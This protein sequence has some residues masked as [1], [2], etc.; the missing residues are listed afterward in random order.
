[1]RNVGLQ[2]STMR[3][4]LL[5]ITLTLGAFSAFAGN[6][7]GQRIGDFD[8][9]SN[10]NGANYTGQRIGDFYYWSGYDQNGCYHSGTGQ[11]IGSFTYW[12]DDK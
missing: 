10:S 2:W 11:R 8:Y 12:D 7:T 4:L 3:R 1:M 9:W 5:T 6:W